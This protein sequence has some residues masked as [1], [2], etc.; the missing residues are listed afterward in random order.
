ME[1]AP[2]ER[3]TGL[4]WYAQSSV[5][6]TWLAQVVLPLARAARDDHGADVLYLGRG[7]KHGSHID[8]VA[9][10][11][12]QVPWADF[13]AGLDWRTGELPEPVTPAAYLAH[14]REMGRLERVPP[15]YLPMRPRGTLEQLCGR[16]E[17]HWPAALDGLRDQALTTLFP[18][19]AHA[20][21]QAARSGGKV[22]VAALAEAFVGLCAAHPRGPAYGAFS[23][24]SHAEAF[25][26]WASA[27]VDP[28]PAFRRRLA[29]DSAAFRTL[30]ERA[31]G[32]GESFGDVG[33]ESVDAG[34]WRTG[35]AVC[36]ERFTAAAARGELTAELLEA[37]GHGD[38][39]GMGPP[40]SAHQPPPGRSEFHEAVEASGAGAGP[41]GWFTAYR[42]L[43][44]LFYSRLPL[45]G[46]TPIQRYYLCFAIAECTDQ[47]FGGSWRERLPVPQE[48]EGAP[49]EQP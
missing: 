16:H 15:P 36:M 46:V 45:L 29:T 21:E 34:R 7:W 3:T 41:Q 14:A 40:G 4:R 49:N 48:Q 20:L 18:P 32:G 1:S 30:L 38:R 42:L 5:P 28:R 25:L 12:R 10:G 33:E 37:A 8:L 35:F 6:P 23:L 9:H 13:T 22:P 11:P 43:I 19:I 44:N 17:P 24:R 39:Q 47:V 27:S 26:H 2:A 31:A